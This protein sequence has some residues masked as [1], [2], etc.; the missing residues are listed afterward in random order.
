MSKRV[1]FK[2][3]ACFIGLMMFNSA[4]ADL[5]STSYVDGQITP[6]E[7][8][9]D[10]H[11][12]DMYGTTDNE[13]SGYANVLNNETQKFTK[14]PTMA[15]TNQMINDS[16]G[17]KVNLAVP[18]DAN[19]VMVRGAGGVAIK[20]TGTDITVNNGAI[21]VNHATK[22]TKDNDGNVI[23][24]TYATQ[25]TV[26]G[27]SDKIGTVPSGK[28]LVDMI[29]EA[30]SAATYDD[31][32]LAAR[33]TAN[34]NAITTLNGTASTSGS[35]ANSIA[36]ALTDYSKTGAD[37][38]YAAASDLSAHTGNTDIHV[39]TADKAAWNA[40]QGALTTAQLAAAN[41]GITA[42]KVGNYD[43][44]IA[45]TDIHVTTADKAAWNAKQ[46]AISDL[47]DIRAGAAAGATA[48][49]PSAISDMETQTHASNT[50][51]AK[52]L[53]TNFTNAD[54]SHYPSA[55]AVND[56]LGGKQAT[57]SD[58]ATIR[59]NATAGAGAAT[60]IAGYG[61]IVTHN[62]AE[63][64]TATQ[65]T[66]AASALQAA[67]ITTGATNGTIAVDGTDVA[68]KGLGSA[69]YKNVTNS[70]S[71]SGT[72]PVTGTAVASA[73]SG[74][75]T[76]ANNAI[77][78]TVAADATTLIGRDKDG[79]AGK[80]TLTDLTY[81]STASGTRTLAVDTATSVG[82]STKPVTAKAVNDKLATLDS[83]SSG[84][85]NVVVGVIQT[86]GKVAVTMGSIA[87]SDVTNLTTDLAA[88]EASANKYG[89][90]T[91]EVSG[92][93]TVLNDDT[94]KYVKYPTMAVTNQM[95][96]DSQAN[97]VNMAI[98]TDANS[99]MVRG[100][101][102]A[103]MK[104]TGS[105]ITV[106]GNGAITVNHA[107]KATK[108]NDGNVI[109]ST[110]ATQTTVNGISDKVGSG[111]ISAKGGD[112]STAAADLVSAVNA[113]DTRLS[114]ATTTANNAI[115][116]DGHTAKRVLTSDKNGNVVD[117]TIT[118]TSGTG[119][120]VSVND[121]GNITVAGTKATSS[122]LGV[123]KGGGNVAIDNNGQLSV[124]TASASTAGVTKLY[125][126]TGSGTDGAMSQ[127]ATTTA[128]SGKQDALPVPA[129]PSTAGV[130]V[131][132]AKV[133]NNA[134][135]YYWEDI[136]R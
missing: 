38:T 95:I 3:S 26:N 2:F 103:A 94:Q 12:D 52:A 129:T 74:V 17:L 126:G 87:E 58:L 93:S 86:D 106:A 97:K 61:D 41:S 134:V 75:T 23:T 130:Y 42:T 109:T 15:M 6:V 1:G 71:A 50:Y 30:Q 56:A 72:D 81:T 123:V 9:I 69:A 102:G 92:Y 84:T 44:H 10:N 104:G 77:P 55:K 108:D 60:T 16:Q 135:S 28:T 115:A 33:V 7:T 107:T 36:A 110:Y 20:G 112:D 118:A 113:I 45:D 125:T 4:R 8:K 82:T 27:I 54:D 101:G 29:G 31:T 63:F 100:T 40:K 14:Y 89:T 64:A 34:E 53:V 121:S 19:S 78:K 99:V 66:L 68:V 49:Q 132:T 43:D 128:L 46:G 47:A 136:G 5:A 21:T 48:V 76:T 90:T 88:K 32:A 11:I 111:T 79:L 65:G 131:L 57:I 37:S 85:G 96:N 35:V 105:D 127:S 83:T 122:A 98:T 114:N 18:N 117:G 51:Q 91:A 124:G 80:V 13:L 116:D 133:E 22:A 73:I 70:Y 39:T 120:S 24:S 25:T 59:S 119:V 62:A 67:D